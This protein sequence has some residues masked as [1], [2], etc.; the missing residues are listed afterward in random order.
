MD[1][2]KALLRGIIVEALQSI[3]PGI[4]EEA[5]HFERPRNPGHGDLSCTV[6]LALG[7]SLKRNPREI[8]TRLL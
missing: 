2:P 5:L 7:R 8:A 6:A 4:G 1:D 3:S